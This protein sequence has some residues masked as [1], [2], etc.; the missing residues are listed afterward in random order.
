MQLKSLSSILKKNLITYFLFPLFVFIFLL[1]FIA[2]AFNNINSSLEDKKYFDTIKVPLINSL[3]MFQLQDSQMLLNTLAVNRDWESAFILDLNNKVIISYPFEKTIK[4]NDI[5]F[6]KCNNQ[7]KLESKDNKVAELCFKR[8]TWSFINY[9]LIAIALGTIFIIILCM[10]SYR[11]L[12]KKLEYFFNKLTNVISSLENLK[13]DKINPAFLEEDRIILALYKKLQLLE[14]LKIKEIENAEITAKIHI[15]EQVAHDIRSPLDSI[16]TIINNS[17]AINTF[18]LSI[19]NNSIQRINSISSNILKPKEDIIQ[20]DSSVK[21]SK[22]NLSTLVNIII[23]EKKAQYMNRSNIKLE[24]V[25]ES[26]DE[27]VIS[28]NKNDLLRVLSNLINNSYEAINEKG[29]INLTLK[30]NDDQNASLKIQ[31]SGKGIPESV[32]RR[33]GQR[34]VSFGKENSLNSGSGLGLYSAKKTIE[35]MGG[36]LSISSMVPNGT[37]INLFFPI[38]K[39]LLEYDF[40]YI[41]DDELSRLVWQ[42]TANKKKI[43]LLVLDSLK[44]FD[45]YKENINK[46]NT[47]IYIDSDL[48]SGNIKGEEFALMLYENGYKNLIMATGHP[49]E[50]FLDYPWLKHSS[51]KCPF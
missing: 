49:A 46:E 8:K 28:T 5:N 38:I 47:K 16:Y 2:L 32:L 6:S 43:R 31:D 36:I 12:I 14:S 9:N 1:S 35:E 19:V 42:S 34:G 15:A 44:D 26:N 23:N 21:F 18:D 40:V 41:D 24:F 37:E 17:E 45:K 39:Q 22:E 30:K 3:I 11:I 4:N 29:F 48:G 10:V 13:I 51:K 27:I 25:D 7:I 50:R 33:L 20:C